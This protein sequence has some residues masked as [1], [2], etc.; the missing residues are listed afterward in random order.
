MAGMHLSHCPRTRASG[1]PDD[2]ASP[3][4]WSCCAAR[5]LEMK[6]QKNILI[7]VAETFSE[8]VDTTWM[9][10]M[11]LDAYSEADRVVLRQ[12]QICQ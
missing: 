8:D 12:G 6:A 5:L 4:R 10:S 1:Y 2:S 3:S 9:G 11:V 7:V